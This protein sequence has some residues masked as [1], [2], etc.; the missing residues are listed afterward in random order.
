VPLRTLEE[1]RLQD[2]E[3]QHSDASYDRRILAGDGCVYRVLQPERTTLS[4]RVARGGDRRDI[5]QV[6]GL[7]RLL[8]PAFGDA[9]S[10]S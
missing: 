4:L 8:Q 3:M 9:A 2:A 7:H 10:W 5:E 1:V 6:R